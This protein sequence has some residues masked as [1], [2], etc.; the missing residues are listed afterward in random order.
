[1][2]VP[3][4]M[5]PLPTWLATPSATSSPA[6]VSGALRFAEPDGQTTDPSGPAAARAN[7]SARQVKE[8]GSMTSG[9]YGPRSTTSSKSVALQQSLESRL[10]AKTQTLGSTL[11]K[12]TWKPWVTPS[13]PSR[14]RLRASVLRTSETACT[15]W[16]TPTVVQASMVID[17]DS[18]NGSYYLKPDGRKQQTDLALTATQAG[19]PTP[20]ASDMVNSNETPEQWEARQDSARLRNPNIGG[21]HKKLSIVAKS[22]DQPARLTASGE[23]LTG[24][25]AATS[26][27]GQLNPAHSRWLMGLPPEWDDCAPTVTPSTRKRRASGSKP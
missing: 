13:G 10:R 22:C 18:W 21:L 1:M 24:S 6:L 14:F 25:S 16:P 5:L 8:Q 2:S 9:T 4:W 17:P 26:A 12:L 19:W 11:Y 7:L 3:S 23:M 27:G 15:G 20:S